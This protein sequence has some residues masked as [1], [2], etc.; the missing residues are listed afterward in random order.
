[1]VYNWSGS[2]GNSG[3]GELG[4]DELMASAGGSDSRWRDRRTTGHHRSTHARHGVMGQ[5]RLRQFRLLVARAP[6]RAAISTFA[7]LGTAAVLT[8]LSL[9]GPAAVADQP[10]LTAFRHVDHFNVGAA[11]SPQL[12]RQLAAAKSRTSAGTMAPATPIANAAKGID[13]ASFQESAGINWPGVASEG[14]QFAAVKGTEGDYYQNPYALSDLAKAKAAGLAV[15][16]Y[17]FAIPNGDGASASPVTQADDLINYLKSGPSGVPPIMLDIEYDPYADGT[18]QCY[19]LSQA[20]MLAWIEKFT[21]EVKSRTGQPAI[22]YSTAGWWKACVGAVPSPNPFASNPLWVAA[23]TSTTSP[24]TLPSAWSGSNWTYWQYGS[25][26]SIPVGTGTAAVDQDQLNP[27]LLAVLNPGDQQDAATGAAI[28]PVQLHASQG[29]T[30]AAT[31]VPSNLSV[32]ST[33]EITGTAPITAGTSTVTVTATSAKGATSSVTFT[34]YWHGSLSVAAPASQST[35]GGSP[36]DLQV[37][38]SD[39]PSEPPVMFSSPKLPAGLSMTTAGQITGWADA[40]PATYQVTTYAADHLQAASSAAFPWTVRLAPDTGPTGAVHLNLAGKC[41]QDPGDSSA[42]GTVA[43][44]WTCNNTPAQKWTYAQDDSLR[45]NGNCL[46]SPTAQGGTVTLAT[47]TGSSRQ[48]WQLVYPRSVNPAA[49]G[50]ALSLY[51]PA[52][53]M[54]LSDPNSSRVN[55]TGQI[56]WPCAGGSNREWTLPAGPVQSGIAGKCL[57]DYHNLTTNGT[58]VDLNT[59]NGSAAQMWSMATD[60]SVR[61][62]SKCLDVNSGGTAAGTRVELYQCNGTTAQQWRLLSNGGG[63]ML[64]NPPSGL[65]LTDTADSMVNGKQL[66][67]RACEQTDP[68][69]NWRAS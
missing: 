5:H 3:N 4:R 58:K 21:A 23:V 32:S 31:S 22:I 69:R 45:I 17:A 33:G 67:I 64:E 40:A 48:Q 50:T 60:N 11:H 57:D 16:A 68:G 46:Q 28:T 18:N 49:T 13:V 34:W 43:Q 38:A 56:A 15:A 29:V 47:C 14:D 36:V 26:G 66:Q 1:M 8:A 25:N 59:C 55:G 12:L 2:F 24:G 30:Y 37:K 44:I 19:G 10:V 39:S 35:V 9:S 7:G 42:T 27:G 41:L 63:V 65:C 52:L 61:I 54:C 6:A 51:N 62:H 53:G 20:A